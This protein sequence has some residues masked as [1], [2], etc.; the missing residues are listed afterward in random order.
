[1]L[2]VRN[3]NRVLPRDELKQCT[4]QIAELLE[5][6]G[7]NFQRPDLDQMFLGTCH[8]L[9]VSPEPVGSQQVRTIGP[10][11]SGMIMR[12]KVVPLPS[13]FYV[14]DYSDTGAGPA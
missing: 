11:A 13:R 5:S 4:D 10:M 3:R 9:S 7:V 6:Y 14:M 2:S 1:M 12:F 8:D